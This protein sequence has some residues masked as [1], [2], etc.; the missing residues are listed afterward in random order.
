MIVVAVRDAAVRAEYVAYLADQ[1]LTAV[2]ASD[3]REAVGMVERLLP[4][5][6]VV[7]LDDEG[8][9]AARSLRASLPTAQVGIVAL[10]GPHGERGAAVCDLVLEA[11]CSPVTLFTE[12]VAL[13]AQLG[14][15]SV[16][17]P[18]R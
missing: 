18:V 10:G 15:D 11:P 9:G 17:V 2:A 6:V 16:V 1:S 5:I 14:P 12:L 4:E 7:D 13:L 3:A 8:L